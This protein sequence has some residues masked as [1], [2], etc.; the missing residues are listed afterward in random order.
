MTSHHLSHILLV[1]RKS[2]VPPIISGR[3]T[4]TGQ[5]TSRDYWERG[6]NLESAHLRALTGKNRTKGKIHVLLI[7]RVYGKI[8]LNIISVKYC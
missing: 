3:D 8:P 2:Q 4:K 5:L 1:R 7:L 6:V